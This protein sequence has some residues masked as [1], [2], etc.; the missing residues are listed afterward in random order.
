LKLPEASAYGSLKVIR[1]GD[2]SYRRQTVDGTAIQ[3]QFP[4][5][6]HGLATVATTVKE[7]SSSPLS[8]ASPD[9]LAQ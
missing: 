1:S 4:H 7:L 3:R 5:D 2:G 9:F 6:V 8:Y